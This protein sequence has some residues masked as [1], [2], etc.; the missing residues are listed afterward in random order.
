[1]LRLFC[2][3]G[4]RKSLSTSANRKKLYFPI[5]D[6]KKGFETAIDRDFNGLEQSA[7]QIFQAFEAIQP[8]N[9]P[10]LG[11]FNRINNKNKHEDLVPQKRT[12]ERRVKVSRNG[13]SVSWGQGVTFGGGVSVMGV[14]I[15]PRTQRPV[16]NSI[17]TT[18]IET[19]VSFVFSETNDFVLPFVQE[20]I[21]KVEKFYSDIL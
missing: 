8:F 19:W 18:N 17:A 5:R 16:P 7:N 2:P 6:S 11:K 15:D 12:E 14:P 13:G 4:S 10:W 3:R 21:E 1:M 9:D 20:S